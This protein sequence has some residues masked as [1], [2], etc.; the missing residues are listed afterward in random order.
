MKKER[1][2]VNELAYAFAFILI[3]G[4]LAYGL[5]W[6]LHFLIDIPESKYFVFG[7]ILEL[8]F[9][10]SAVIHHTCKEKLKED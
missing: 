7:I 6:Y 4:A 9:I 10:V 5:G 2:F 1:F 8:I 3:A